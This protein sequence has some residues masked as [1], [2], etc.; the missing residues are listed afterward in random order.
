LFHEDEDK[1]YYAVPY[2]FRE[3]D[4]RKTYFRAGNVSGAEVVPDKE[5][6]HHVGEPFII[7]DDNCYQSKTFYVR[8]S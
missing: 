6:F 8:Y 5:E 4:D 3:N 1:I 7:E 2:S